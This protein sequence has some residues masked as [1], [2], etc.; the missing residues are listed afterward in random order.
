M[1]DLPLN[2]ALVDRI[3]RLKLLYTACTSQG[4]QLAV[5]WAPQGFI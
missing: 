4:P 1:R 3:T 2:R 5:Y